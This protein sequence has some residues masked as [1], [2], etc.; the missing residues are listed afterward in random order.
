VKLKLPQN[1]KIAVINKQF[2]NIPNLNSENA[3]Y[4][5]IEEL[6]MSLFFQKH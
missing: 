6:V 5:S 4:F 2:Q 1:Y 3:L